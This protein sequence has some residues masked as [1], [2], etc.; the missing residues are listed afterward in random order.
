M[1]LGTT[2]VSAVAIALAGA[3]AAC[4]EHTVTPIVG[5]PFVPFGH[6]QTQWRPYPYVIVPPEVRII[7]PSEPAK[8]PEPLPT[9]QKTPGMNPPIKPVVLPK[10]PAQATEPR[11]LGTPIVPPEHD[12]KNLII[13]QPDPKP[14][15]LIVPLMEPTSIDV[16]VINLEPGMK[17][18]VLPEIREPQ[19]IE[20][21]ALPNNRPPV[22]EMRIKTS[23]G[24]SE[25]PKETP[26][27]PTPPK[28]PTSPASATTPG[29]ST[30]KSPPLLDSFRRSN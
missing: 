25:V 23:D 27:L 3:A 19:V 24:W 6:Y 2:L 11:R 26:T 1:K 22:P 13:P 30:P 8:L 12:P 4:A 20:P 29:T 5:N 28:S 21:K 17:N 15:Q 16:P 14:N 7:V 18:Q 10:V 9:K